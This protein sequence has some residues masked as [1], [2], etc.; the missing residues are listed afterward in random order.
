MKILLKRKSA[1]KDLNLM[2]RSKKWA[3]DQLNFVNYKL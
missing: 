1:K 3:S 2:L